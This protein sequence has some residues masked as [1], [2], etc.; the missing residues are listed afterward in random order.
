MLGGGWGGGWRISD[1]PEYSI[2]RYSIKWTWGVDCNKK[3]RNYF[4]L[5]YF[6]FTSSKYNISDEK[7]MDGIIKTSHVNKIGTIL[8]K[9]IIYKNCILLQL[10]EYF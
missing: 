10:K 3:Q 2:T 9:S 7:M 8:T 1:Y 4:L 6:F 5:L